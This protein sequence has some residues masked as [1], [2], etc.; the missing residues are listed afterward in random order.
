LL[1]LLVRSGEIEHIYID[2]GIQKLLYEHAVDKH[3]LSKGALR[4]WMEYPRPSG[5][6]AALIQHVKGHTDHMHVRFRCQPDEPRCK[7]RD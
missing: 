6:G 2:R 4:K 3:L 1:Q 5:S 7:S